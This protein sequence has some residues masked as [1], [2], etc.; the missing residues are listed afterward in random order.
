MSSCVFKW[1]Q[2]TS[3]FLL[4]LIII[5]GNFWIRFGPI[6]ILFKMPF[7]SHEKYS[8]TLGNNRKICVG[9]ISIF[10]FKIFDSLLERKNAINV[11]CLEVKSNFMFS[12]L[13]HFDIVF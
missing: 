8:L 3:V 9:N 12:F 4:N 2:I 1:F 11:I 6:S 7:K 13:C 10:I 5:P